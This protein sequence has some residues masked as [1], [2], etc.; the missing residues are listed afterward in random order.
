MK[1]VVAFAAMDAMRTR[2]CLT[3]PIYRSLEQCRLKSPKRFR[4]LSAKRRKRVNYSCCA[5]RKECLDR[6]AKEESDALRSVYGKTLKD[7]EA[8]LAAVHQDLSISRDYI[9]EILAENAELRTRVQCSGNC[10]TTHQKFVTFWNWFCKES[11]TF[12]S[13][14]DKKPRNGRE[15]EVLCRYKLDGLPW[16]AT[17]VCMRG[18]FRDHPNEIITHWR[19]RYDEKD[20]SDV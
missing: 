8:E 17:D 13:I 4:V 18:K 5:A 14:L 3:D 19:Y 2:Y 6:V 9:G 20:E 16:R 12:I 15:I 1:M 10:I 11:D 7:T